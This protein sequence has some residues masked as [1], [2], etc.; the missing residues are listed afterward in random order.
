[1]P[2]DEFSFVLRGRN[3]RNILR[4]FL[5]EKMTAVQISKA[6]SIPSSNVARNIVELRDR[7]LIV[8]LTKER[9]F[10]FYKITPKGRKVLKEVERIR[11]MLQK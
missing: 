10:R 9:K 5:Q 8:A 3:R 4:A 2:F 11:K 7:K 1:M 6:L